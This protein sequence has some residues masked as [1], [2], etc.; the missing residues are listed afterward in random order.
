MADEK[1]TEDDWAAWR[2]ENVRL[3]LDGWTLG[4]SQMTDG[5]VESW[6]EKD[7]IRIR[8]DPKWERD[9]DGNYIYGKPS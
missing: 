9:A 7:G 6:A 5:T 8:R 1:W 2:S 4:I 3:M